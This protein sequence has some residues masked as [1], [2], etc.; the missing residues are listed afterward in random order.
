MTSTEKL[1]QL[2]LKNR[3]L[4]DNILQDNQSDCLFLFTDGEGNITP[5]LNFKG[6]DSFY[7][8]ITIMENEGI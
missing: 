4:E 5:L 1:K 2:L 6:D 7:K 8:V 3:F